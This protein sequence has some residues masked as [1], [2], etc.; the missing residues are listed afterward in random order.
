MKDY[1]VLD[2][3]IPK[4]QELHRAIFDKGYEQ[5]QKDAL[6]QEPKA[7][8]CEDCISREEAI[9]WM[10]NIRAL[11]RYYHPNEDDDITLVSEVISRLNQLPSVTPKEK[12]AVWV[13]IDQEPH[14]VYECNACGWLLYDE[15]RTDFKYCP[16]CGARMQEVEEN[17]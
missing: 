11:N 7:G 10:E 3:L 5:G 12:T 2:E 15:N 8:H 16:N 13:G 14:E 9:K 4:T 1:V 17:G 6:E